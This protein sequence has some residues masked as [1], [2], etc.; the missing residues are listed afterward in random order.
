MWWGVEILSLH[1]G[2]RG[3]A[4]EENLSL[5]W[6][7]WLGIWSWQM[8]GHFTS[9]PNQVLMLSL[10]LL[11][12]LLLIR[13]T[14]ISSE[15]SSSS[16][17]ACGWSPSE[18]AFNCFMWLMALCRDPCYVKCVESLD[19]S[20]LVLSEFPLRLQKLIWS[21]WLQ[22]QLTPWVSRIISLYASPVIHLHSWAFLFEQFVAL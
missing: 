7:C 10:W 1:I 20:P 21:R 2:N 11:H 15:T 13:E 18:A 3:K 6:A 5:S 9:S 14:L 19:Q 12:S 17:S 8:N 4:K 22:N 16:V